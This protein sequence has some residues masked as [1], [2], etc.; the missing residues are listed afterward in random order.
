MDRH[1]ALVN[2][3]G[4]TLAELLVAS[5]V[6]GLL[7]LGVFTLQRGVQSL[8]IWCYDGNNVLTTTPGNMRSV[9]RSHGRRR[10]TGSHRAARITTRACSSAG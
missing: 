10:L 8:Q 2:Q 7:M 3:R 9:R 5:A 4:F 6:L 1:Q